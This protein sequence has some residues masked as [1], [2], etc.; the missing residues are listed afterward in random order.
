M[1]IEELA[2]ETKLAEYEIIRQSFKEKDQKIWELTKKV[3]LLEGMLN[4]AASLRD[5][6][7]QPQPLP[8][9]RNTPRRWN[10]K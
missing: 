7:P 10:V 9:I 2:R 4:R 1:D 8:A 6:V 3:E 5:Y